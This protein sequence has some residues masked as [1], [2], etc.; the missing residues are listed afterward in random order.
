MFEDSQKLKSAVEAFGPD[1]QTII[2]VLMNPT[3]F[4]SGGRLSYHYVIMRVLEIAD[5]E[6]EL[7]DFYFPQLLQVHS[8]ILMKL[9]LLYSNNYEISNQNCEYMWIWF[10]QVHLQESRGRSQ[11]SMWKVDLLQ[12]A[13]LVLSQKYPPLAA[14]L[15]WSLLASIS[16]YVDHKR[17]YQ[18]YDCLF[19]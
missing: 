9:V 5:Y 1:M 10:G 12:Q 6:P 4:E 7:I 16:D 15:A 19:F 8:I 18:V 14:K 13:L 3:L 2:A 11:E 17:I